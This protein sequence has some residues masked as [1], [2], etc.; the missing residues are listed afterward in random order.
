MRC[1]HLTIPQRTWS[2]TPPFTI[3]SSMQ[4]YNNSAC[5]M[6]PHVALWPHLSKVSIKDLSNIFGILASSVFRGPA[7]S[8]LLAMA[9][10]G[11]KYRIRK[12]NIRPGGY[13]DL[14]LLSNLY[15]ALA[16]PHEI[17]LSA[18]K[19]FDQIRFSDELKPEFRG[20]S[21]ATSQL[22]V[23]FSSSKGF[24]VQLASCTLEQILF[25]NPSP[26]PL[27]TILHQQRVWPFAFASCQGRRY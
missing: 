17:H 3:A 11:T 1:D 7:G 21:F 16:G 9:D 19:E 24:S 8:Q 25:L 20:I 26:L 22:D 23:L 18:D 5:G 12:K 4:C 10:P 15:F 27:L 2:R 6:L 14:I 13:S